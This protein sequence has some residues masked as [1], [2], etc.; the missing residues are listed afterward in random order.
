MKALLGCFWEVLARSFKILSSSRFSYVFSRLY[1]LELSGLGA[2]AVALAE[3]PQSLIYH[4]L[5][6]I[7]CFPT[8]FGVRRCN[9]SAFDYGYP[10]KWMVFVREKS[11]TKMD[12][13]GGTQDELLKPSETPISSTLQAS[14]AALMCRWIS[15]LPNDAASRACFTSSSL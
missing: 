12:F 15:Q 11:Q 4:S 1:L 8:L 5:S 2:M 14:L 10:K 3:L 7:T 9:V 6:Q 13:S